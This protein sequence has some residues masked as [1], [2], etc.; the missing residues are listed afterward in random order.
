MGSSIGLQGQQSTY[1]SFGKGL[2][3]MHGGHRMRWWCVRNVTTSRLVADSA[4]GDGYH[5]RERRDGRQLRVSHIL[6]HP[7][8]DEALEEIIRELRESQNVPQTFAEMAQKHST[9]PSRAKGGDL[10]W[11]TVGQMVAEFEDACFRCNVGDIVQC[12]TEYGRHL[13]HVLE[14]QKKSLVLPMSV[15]ELGHV[16]QEGV[17]DAYQLIDVRE[18]WEVET[19]RI[20]GFEVLPLSQFGEWGMNVNERLD[21]TKTTICLC[22]HGIRS[23]QVCQFLSARDFDDLRNVTGG[24]DAYSR[25]VDSSI[26]TY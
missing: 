14:E 20:P 11:V 24:I 17:G 21:P 26:P 3:E 12:E 8:N 6:L 4:S 13:V 25:I 10:G 9:C 18:P 15:E 2:S 1:S 5:E 23:M 7:D 22:H 19:A 16:L